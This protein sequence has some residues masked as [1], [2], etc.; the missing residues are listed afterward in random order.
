MNFNV[1]IKIFKFLVKINFIIIIF[2]KLNI[3]MSKVRN[4][5]YYKFYYFV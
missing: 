5:F 4:V 3:L 2:R 1:K